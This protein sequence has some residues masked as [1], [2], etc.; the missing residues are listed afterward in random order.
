MK[1]RP[2][3]HASCRHDRCAHA[4]LICVYTYIYIYTVTYISELFVDT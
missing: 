3:E 1:R 4:I 2:E